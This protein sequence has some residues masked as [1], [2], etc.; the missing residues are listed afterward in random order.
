MEVSRPL[1]ATPAGARRNTRKRG[2]AMNKVQDIEV[3]AVVEVTPA[4]KGAGYYSPDGT[5]G[6][7]TVV[8]I[9][10]P[11]DFYLVRG[12]QPEAKKSDWDLI[13][14]FSRLSPVA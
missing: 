5:E 4:Y 11:G 6:V 12:V 13:S 7:Y 2:L 1:T 8:G 10:P 9:L 14:H 3:G